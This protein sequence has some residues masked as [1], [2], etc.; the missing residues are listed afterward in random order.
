MVLQPH[1]FVSSAYFHVPVFYKLLISISVFCAVFF[2][3]VC[4]FVQ[5]YF[6][7]SFIT[8]NLR[9]CLAVSSQDQAIVH[10]DVLHKITMTFSHSNHT[11]LI[12]LYIP[13]FPFS[14]I[15]ILLR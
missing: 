11:M 13:V 7:F 4:S 12:S 2:F 1:S 3:P 10:Q 6:I 8:T 5:S 14:D 15:A 9:N